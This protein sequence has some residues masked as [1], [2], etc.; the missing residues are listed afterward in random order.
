M[1]M[2]PD[3]M[4]PAAVQRAFQQ[5]HPCAG[6]QDAIFGLRRP[7]LSARDA[8][9]LPMD[10]MT[11]DGFVDHSTRFPRDAGH[12]REI[13][14]LHRARGKL[15]REI[16]VGRIVLG[17]DETAARLLVESMDNSRA[18]LSADAREIL[19]NAPSKALTRV[20]C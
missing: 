9:P 10:R 12:Q 3:L 5:A 16:A 18:L 4:R 20:C 11:G 1:E 17:H 7:P 13:D 14:F 2:H 19:C 15:L 8:H 6:A